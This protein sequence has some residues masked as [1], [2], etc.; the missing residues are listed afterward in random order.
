M[1]AATLDIL[2]ALTLLW[3]KHTIGD[4]FL[5]STWQVMNKSRYGHPGGLVHSAIHV[6]MTPIVFLVLPTPRFA[7]IGAI[8]ASEFIVHYHIDWGKEQIV[9]AGGWSNRDAAYWRAF[10]IDQFA[11][12]ATYV[13]IVLFVTSR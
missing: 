3:G 12:F 4:Y 11:H 9:K 13:A 2:L 5:Q 1:N 7:L 8:L 10:G 6:A